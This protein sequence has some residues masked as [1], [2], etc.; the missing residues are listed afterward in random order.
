MPWCFTAPFCAVGCCLICPLLSD[1][2]LMWCFLFALCWFLALKSR[3]CWPQPCGKF[4]L[5]VLKFCA[6]AFE[7][8]VRVFLKISVLFYLGKCFNQNFFFGNFFSLGQF[9]N[10]SSD[11]FCVSSPVPWSREGC[12]LRPFG[13]FVWGIRFSETQTLRQGTLLH[14][15]GEFEQ[16]TLLRAPWSVE[17]GVLL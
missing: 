16:G 3:H 1:F 9:Q 8:I 7:E 10:P 12:A 6:Q 5:G 13:T 15:S 17:W 11:Y 14:G 2:P 4:T